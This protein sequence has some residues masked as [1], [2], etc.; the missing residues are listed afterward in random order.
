MDDQRGVNAEGPMNGS[1]YRRLTVAVNWAMARVGTLDASERFE[2]SYAITQE[3]AEWL[4][5]LDEQPDLLASTVQMVPR[6]PG[7]PGPTRSHPF[8]QDGLLEI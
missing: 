1:A 7:K 3:F 4:L 2:D 8:Q 6:N 5:C